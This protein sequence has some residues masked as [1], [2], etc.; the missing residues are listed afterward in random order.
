MAILRVSLVEMSYLH[1]LNTLPI[2]DSN[3]PAGTNSLFLVE[4]TCGCR[5]V[6]GRDAFLGDPR[7]W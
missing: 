3:F 1:S 4:E 7:P 5:L 6:I 2:G